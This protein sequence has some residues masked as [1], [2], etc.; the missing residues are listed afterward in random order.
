MKQ[1]EREHLIHNIIQS[2]KGINGPKKDDIINRQLCHFFRA[3]I[4]L[5]MKVSLG[6]N[7][8][9]DMNMMNHSK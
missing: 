5:G 1:E 2:M 7:I 6:L 3:N 4:E 9:I 8:N